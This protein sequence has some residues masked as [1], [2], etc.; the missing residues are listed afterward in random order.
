MFIPVIA[1]FSIQIILFL[2]TIITCCTLYQKKETNNPKNNFSVQVIDRPIIN[3]ESPPP[4]TDLS[5]TYK[6]V[7]K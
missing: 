5:L 6:K 4:Y 3:T 2:K 7:K 1:L